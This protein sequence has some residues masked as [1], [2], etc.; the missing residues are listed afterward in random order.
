MIVLYDCSSFL[1]L[2]IKS[3]A[4]QT[5][6]YFWIILEALP[7]TQTCVSML[8]AWP[9]PSC[10]PLLMWP[11]ILRVERDWTSS[12]CCDVNQPSVQDG[13][14]DS[15]KLHFK[16]KTACQSLGIVGMACL[17]D[18]ILNLGRSCQEHS[19]CVSSRQTVLYL[20]D[21]V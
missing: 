5:L 17:C 7:Q 6:F 18:Q 15:L 9:F 8:I 10:S 1:I 4:K 13:K 21:S 19:C 2:E 3:F 12:K 20:T 14:A 11:G 16:L